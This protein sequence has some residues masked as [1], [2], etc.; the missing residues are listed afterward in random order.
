MQGG[1]SLRFHQGLIGKQ[2]T[3]IT[4]AG[5][6]FTKPFDLAKRRQFIPSFSLNLHTATKQ[7]FVHLIDRTIDKSFEHQSPPGEEFLRF[8][9]VQ[10][11]VGLLW[12][13]PAVEIGAAATYS[14]YQELG[15]E[16]DEL[17][18]FPLS[19]VFHAAKKKRGKR[20][21]LISQPVKASPE[22]VVIFSENVFM[23][24][25]GLR[26]ERVDHQLGIFAQNDFMW[27]SHGIGGAYSWKLN[28]LRLH[29][30]AGTTYSVPHKKAAFFGEAA[31]G[32]IIPYIQINDKNPWAPPPRSF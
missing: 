22:A 19:V 30:S 6:A 21:G 23:S 26:L 18:R 32:L 31:L 24:R 14:F 29:L 27:N 17:S 10:P 9:A 20:N 25:V 28:N 4:G 2:N 1:V 16:P 13:S 12:N 15:E 8:A 11:G 5:F 7:W 3:N